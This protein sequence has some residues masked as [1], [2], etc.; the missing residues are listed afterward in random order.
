VGFG[1]TV[2]VS[3]VGVAEHGGALVAD[4]F[5]GAVVDGGGGVQAQPAVTVF[6]TRV[7]LGSSSLVVGVTGTAG[8]TDVGERDAVQRGVELPVAPA[9]ESVAL[10]AA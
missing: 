9:G 6:L 7:S 5:G 2:W 3:P 1:R 10:G 8:H 4:G